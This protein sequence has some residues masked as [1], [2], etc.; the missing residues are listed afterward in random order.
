MIRL[1]L[2]YRPPYDWAGVLAFLARRAI[3]GVESVENEVYRRTISL[4]GMQGIV[5]IRATAEAFLLATITVDRLPALAAVAAR[6][7]HLFDL[8]ADPDTIAAHLGH[9]PVL[10]NRLAVHPG[11]RVPGGWDAFELAVRA[12]IGQQVSVP[13]ASTL[14]RRLVAA[15]GEPLSIP[16][17]DRDP[18]LLFPEPK[19]LA[20]ADLSTIGLPRAR[21]AAISSLSAA[22]VRDPTLLRA[23]N[24]AE[25]TV[26]RLVAFPGIG[27]WTAEYIAMRALREPDA[28]PSS[29]L[30]L[31]R[32]MRR[33]LAR[34]L[35]ALLLRRADSMAAM[36][37]LCGD[38]L[39][40]RR[41]SHQ[42]HASGVERPAYGALTRHVG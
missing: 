8:D 13:G 24:D 5:E 19:R 39:V 10:A 35:P 34:P 17:S 29:D 7:R 27:H 16:T 20:H 32:A 3:P 22:M 37:R 41:G 11:L 2:P 42:H 26:A 6:L 38:A 28:F 4:D 1:R 9:D 15:F 25:Q 12:M 30:G 23:T 31:L 33:H 18:R 14:A 21:A 40:A 36:A